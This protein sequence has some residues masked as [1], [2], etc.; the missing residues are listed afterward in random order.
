M[1]H[2]LLIYSALFITL[3]VS[4]QTPSFHDTQGKLEISNSGAATYTLPI[5]MPPSI[6]DVGPVINLIYSSG[7]SGG[8]AGQGWSINSISTISRIGTRRDL[9]GFIDGVDF[10]D[11]DKLALDG[12]RLLIKTGD[13]WADSAVY[14]TE[15]QSNSKI[16]QFGTGSSIYFVV[17]APDGSRSWY[18]NYGGVNAVD[19]TAFYITR[20]ED[21]NGNYITY[22][23]VRPSNKSLCIYRINFS[24]NLISNISPQNSINFNYKLAKRI[25]NTFIKGIKQER[26]ELLDNIE[27][28]TN[29]N[30]FRKYQLT[31]IVDAQLG[32]EKVSQIQES[33]GAG[34][35]ANPVEFLY[36]QTSSTSD[37]LTEATKTYDNNINFQD[38]KLSGDFDG[39]GRLDFVTNDKMYVKNFEFNTTTAPINVPLNV[40]NRTCLVGTTLNTSNKLNQHQSII[41]AFETTANISFKIYDLIGGTLTFTNEKII[42][43]SNTGISLNCTN[44][45]PSNGTFTYQKDSNLYY[46][47]DFNGDGKSDVLMISTFNEKKINGYSGTTGSCIQF[48]KTNEGVQYSIIDISDNQFNGYY[49]IVNSLISGDKINTVHVENPANNVKNNFRYINDFNGDGKSD[50]LLIDPIDKSYKII[51]FNNIDAGTLPKAMEIMGS[52]VLDDFSDTKQM[53][54]GDYNGDGKTDFMLPDTEGGEGDTQWHIYYSNPNPNGGS[55]FTKESHDIVEYRPNTGRDYNTQTHLS[56]YY[57]LDVNK[58]GKTDM[59]RVWRKFYKPG[60]TI[61]DHDT[62][63]SV[64]TFVNNIGNTLITGNKFT[65]DYV[66][67]CA[68]MTVGN[69]PHTGMPIIHQIC[70]HNSDSPDLPIPIA[71]SFR[72]NGINRE[73]LMVRNHTNEVTYIKFTKDVSNDIL[74]N[75]VSSS[76]GEIVD[77]IEYA[78]L[79]PSVTADGL[80]LQSD[81]YSSGNSV[82]YPNVEIKRLPSS[83]VVSKLKNTSLGVTKYQDFRYHGF[84]TNMDGIGALGFG[85]TARSAWYVNPTA[86]RIWSV[87][88]NNPV[89][90]GAMVRSYSEMLNNG[91]LFSFVSSGNPAGIIN[92][93]TN[94][95]FA[96]V[97]NGVFTIYLETHITE[98][99]LTKVKTENTYTYWPTFFLEKTMVANN[100]LN[101]VLQGTS[102]TLREYDYNST[103]AGSDYFVGKPSRIVSS[104]NA[105]NDTFSTEEKFTYTGRRLTKTE[106]KANNADGVYLTEEF[107]YFPNGNIKKKTLSAPGATPAV[108]PRTTEYTYDSSERFIKTSKDNEG[109]VSTNDSF[110]PLY[111]LVT[112]SID[113]FG[114]ST[115]SVYDNWGKRTIATN[116]LGKNTFY[117][118]TKSGGVYTTLQTGEDGSGSEVKSDALGRII[119]EGSKNING[120]WSYTTTEY[121]FMN[122]KTRKSEPYF[123]TESPSQWSSFVYDEFSRPIQ[124]IAH[125][126]LTTNISYN[127]LTVTTNDGT[128]NSTATKNANGHTVSTSDNGGTVVNTY[129]AN[130][131]LKTATY[132]NNQISMEY[133]GWGRKTKLADPSAGTYQYE[134]N[135][136]GETT[137]EIAPKGITTYDLLPTG[138]L[139]FKTIQGTNGDT[140]NSKTTYTYY[141]V[142]KLVKAS[143]FD[144]FTAGFFTIY[145]YGYDGKNRLNFKDESGTLAYYQQATQYD[146]F[147]RPEKVLYTSINTADGKRS[148]KWIRNTYK[149]GYAWQIIDDATNQVLWQT[150]TVNAR[151]QVVTAGLGNGIAITNTYDQYGYVNQQKHDKTGTNAA[152]MMVLRTAFDNVRGNLLSR[153][154]SLFAWN[155]TFDY[156][157]LDRLTHYKNAAGATM[158]QTYEPDGRIKFNNDQG[159]YNYEN[160]SKKYQNTSVK[161]TKQAS[162]FYTNRAGIF[163]DSMESTTGWLITYGTRISYDFS[164]AKTGTVSLKIPNTTT[165]E[166]KVQSALWTKI[167]NAQATEYTYSGWIKGTGA[168]AEL[169]LYMK[170]ATETGAYTQVDQIISSTGSN[171]VYFEKTVLVPA[172]I[173]KLNL[174]LDNNGSG[175]IWFDDVR[176]RKTSEIITEPKEL[177]ITYNAFNSPVTIEEGN[178]DKITFEYNQSDERSTMYYGGLQADKTQRQYIKSYS[179]D[180]TMEIKQNKSTG[181]AE[182]IT[183]IGGD[184]YSA[185]IVLKSDGTTQEYLYLHR[186]YQGSI[187]AITNQAGV[188]VEKRLFDAWGQVLKI[189]DAQGNCLSQFSVL[190]RGYTGH[191]HLQS[192]EI[193]HMNGRIYDPK[194]HRFLQTDSLIQDP[195]NTQNY[196]R[197]GYC[198]NN[199]LKYTDISGEE[200][201]LLT[202]VII[203]AA[204]A[205]LTYT[206]TAL[207]ADVPFSAGGLL[208]SAAIGAFS[209]AVTFGIGEACSA[210]TNFATRAT[211]QALAH[212]TFQGL[213]SG[214]QG[215]DF[216]TGFAAG[217][218]ASV[219]S[220]AWQGGSSFET[221][222]NV[223]TET[224][225][226]G[227][228]ESIGMGGS[229][230]MIAF[231]TIMGGAGA[232]LTGGNFWQGAVTGLVVS[233]LNHAMDHGDPK[234]SRKYTYRSYEKDE[235]GNIMSEKLVYFKKTGKDQGLFNRSVSEPLVDNTLSVYGHGYNH[236]FNGNSSVVDVDALLFK[237]SAMYRNFVSNHSNLTMNFKS[238]NTGYYIQG[239]EKNISQD[240]TKM[241]SGLTIFA[242]AAYWMS[243]GNVQS[244][245]GYNQFIDGEKVGWSSNR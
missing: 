220:S 17:T 210:I 1:K 154:N 29:G 230:G 223:T 121:D 227:I 242:P 241:R 43:K 235:N 179:E 47:G 122:R 62:Q 33:N 105:Y 149:N 150:N 28:F 9:D 168:T 215:G 171:W 23:Y 190:D 209:A 3:F 173:K 113:P 181:T 70:N 219:A 27:V 7:L 161:S 146:D 114:L 10:D 170:T 115:V 167:D 96:D 110:D 152:N 4:G 89:F 124:T 180:G 111:G 221:S 108:D 87:T 155:E 189:Q 214:V 163:N 133:D 21:T 144:D 182:F 196:N 205:A 50:L 116:Y 213:M 52:G 76:G 239:G 188:I 59:V 117:S 231:G 103:G 16:E 74:L 228:G 123:A 126:E 13:Y 72:F 172:N 137:K 236:N 39:D 238:C 229:G 145:T 49:P 73:L 20:F 148:D 107:D 65:P 243:S 165:V 8:I 64:T 136:F 24:A 112:K 193:I 237:D 18:G 109:F 162:A 83:T 160:T 77:E 80:G 11:N 175:T 125:T 98:D 40:N 138:R 240:L 206:A 94:T 135:I 34:E 147:G 37:S 158:I 26:L 130:G 157:A 225:Q 95:Y 184:G 118:Y 174:R 191:E 75:K 178:L 56:N 233:G 218:L 244:N 132:A 48:V 211:T 134:Y 86:K 71:S 199:P 78:N 30:S 81:F 142:T 32:Y 92:S 2:F 90:R 93:I 127:G 91:N 224:V 15:T 54:F 51:S 129:Y 141:P 131:N 140:T 31:H 208:Q 99:F 42:S 177:N 194:L 67:P 84:V 88:E 156:D 82:N 102:N 202:A 68:S 222:G 57:A 234:S 41:N 197:Y 185:P 183:Y 195:S 6:K 61:N 203:G 200:I 176:I 100:Y 46:E 36:N 128:K 22:N 5:A 120:A 119:R 35:L 153:S 139:N 101:N 58:D 12:Q 164:T 198:W 186:D 44:F 226:K 216:F 187:V 204:I 60:W 212:G 97:I 143:R 151:A 169:F 201:G 38:I 14:Q 45:G 217:C 63:W 79:E 192:V 104:V 207:L 106:K 53:L 25:E 19:N 66:S 232:E 159:V 69:D 55:F 166:K 85:K 245:A